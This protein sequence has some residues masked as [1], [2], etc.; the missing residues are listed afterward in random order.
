[1]PGEVFPNALLGQTLDAALKSLLLLVLGLTALYKM[2][3]S[4]SVN[5]L[6]DKALKMLH[7]K[8]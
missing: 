7:L 5:N 6:I 3:V 8:K 4:L 2:K 1:M